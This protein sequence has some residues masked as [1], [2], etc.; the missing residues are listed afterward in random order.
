MKTVL[1]FVV[2]AAAIA[3]LIRRWRRPPSY[4]YRSVDAIMPAFNEE[5]CIAAS[6]EGLL[7]NP[8]LDQIIVVNDGSS[9]KTAAILNRLAAK[10]KRLVVVHQKNTGKGGALTAGL[11]RARA[12]YVFL[13]DAD[14]YLP[15]DG[16]GLGYMIAEM[17]RGADAVGGVPSSNLDGAGLLPHI[18]ATV[19]LPMIVLKRMFQQI[20]G[21]APFLISGACGMF[22]TDVLRRVPFSDR[23]KVEDLDHTW[24]L[25]A[26]GYRV[27]QTPRCIVYAQECNSLRSEWLRWRRWIVGYAVCMRLHR[28][29]LLSRFG[30]FSIMPMFLVVVVGIASLVTGLV[31]SLLGGDMLSALLQLFPLLWLGVVCVIGLISAIH[32][33]RPWLVALAPAAVF[34][35]F[36]SYAIWLV[37]GLRGL[38]SG[39]EPERDKPERYAHVVA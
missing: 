37:H 21:G 35:V 26:K 16:E 7:E 19:K 31:P 8:Y 39:T 10:H 38:L 5:L 25:V 20:V 11:A 12:R 22:R 17:Q 32:H 1:F 34:Y 36:L 3:W 9:D 23:T 29:L 6:V 18:R 27:R 4:L 30:L 33:R 24:S 2:A 13:T 14:T 28:G 15:P